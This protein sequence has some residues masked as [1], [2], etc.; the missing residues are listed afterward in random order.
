MTAPSPDEVRAQL[1]AIRAARGFVLPH[2]GLMAAALP[3]LH[4]AYEAMYRALTLD[5]RHL[6]PLERESVWLAV[7]AAC[8][9]PVGTHH[10]AKFR[11]AGGTDAQ[12]MALFR[13]AAWAAGAARYA[14]LD[15]AWAQHFPATPIRDAYL[16]GAR[17]LLADGAVAEPLARTC[18]AA[19]HCACDQRWGLEAEIAAALACG[20]PEPCLAEA[21]S[22]TIWPR[23]VNP[24]VRAAEAW[25]ALIRAGRVPASEA[26][27]A[28]AATP[29]QGAFAPPRV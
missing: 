3:E 9:E 21:L 25:L 14:V 23:G 20:V 27:R 4:A 2:H 10:L 17:D 1:A 28:W 22:L 7:L 26:F 18:L 11:A 8:A 29:G 24:F 6:A 13:L 12:A 16:D 19:I 5:P 15:G